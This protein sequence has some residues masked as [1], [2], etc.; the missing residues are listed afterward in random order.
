[1]TATESPTL[2][3]PAPPKRPTSTEV[4]VASLAQHAQTDPPPATPAD[5]R[6]VR[7]MAGLD[8]QHDGVS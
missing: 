4:L 2:I 3:R 6:L 7:W 5:L 1:M 8:T